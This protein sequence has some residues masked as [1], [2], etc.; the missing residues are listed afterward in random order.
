MTSPPR[1]TPLNDRIPS[2][3]HQISVVQIFGH[4]RLQRGALQVEQSAGR[5][6]R[7]PTRF[8]LLVLSQTL[9]KKPAVVGGC[10]AA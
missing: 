3:G 2:Q 5:H 6:G 8:M 4:P 7:L 9:S 10:A 1:Y